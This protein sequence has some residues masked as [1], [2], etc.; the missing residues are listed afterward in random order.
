MR[1]ACSSLA[2]LLACA[3]C[4]SLSN[5]DIAFLSAL[6]R[7]DDL[8]VEVPLPSSAQPACAIGDAADWK[9]AK[10]TGDDINSA[11][12]KVLGLLD[13][14]RTFPPS[15]RKKDLRVWGP[16]PDQQHPGIEYEVSILRFPPPPDAKETLAYLY[17]FEGRRRGGPFRTVIDG[18]FL[19]G[20][21][22]GGQG[23]VGLHFDAAYA[24]GTNA[25]N[26]PH[27]DMTLRY[28]ET[29]EPRTVQLAVG[30][31][32]QGGLAL[33]P[34][35]YFY[36]GYANGSGRFD[37]VL[38]DGRTSKVISAFFKASGAGTATITVRTPLVT[39]EVSECWDDVACLTFVRDPSSV[40]N[41]CGPNTSCGLASAC[42]SVP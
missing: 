17:S 2:L 6:P 3:A 31:L 42:P 29:S 30:S 8:H 26:D 22:K 24:L 15:Q 33:D 34:F 32:G 23:E 11:V 38:N 27:G 41:L 1:S 5:E 39:A 10:A 37:Y 28:D 40:T 36:A 18:F 21:A 13:V 35:D 12:D 14:V 16:F 9:R 25:A 4:G 20:Q 7:K 19:G